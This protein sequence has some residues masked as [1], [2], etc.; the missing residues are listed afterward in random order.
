MIYTKEAINFSQIGPTDFERLCQEI[1]LKYGFKELV[2]RQGGADNGRDLEGY[3]SFDNPF[4]IQKTK[5]FFECKHYSAGVAPEEL[6]SKI[7]WAD[8]EKPNF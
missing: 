7:A 6:N 3:L 4:S 5:W 2:W 8:A 1:L